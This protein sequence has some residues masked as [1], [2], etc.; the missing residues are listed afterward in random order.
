M[1]SQNQIS[2]KILTLALLL[3]AN[4]EFWAVNF[5]QIQSNPL[6]IQT[7]AF[8]E[9]DNHNIIDFNYF[10]KPI[11][12]ILN[13]NFIEIYCY[14][15]AL[16][17][18]ESFLPKLDMKIFNKLNESNN[19]K[20]TISKKL[21]F[22]NDNLIANNIISYGL[23]GLGSYAYPPCGLGSQAF[24]P[25]YTNGKGG[26]SWTSPSTW[27]D[28]KV[29]QKPEYIFVAEGDILTIDSNISI[30]TLYLS[31]KSKV[32]PDNNTRIIEITGNIY[33]NDSASIISNFGSGKLDCYITAANDGKSL[34]SIAQTAKVNFE[35]LK[36]LGETFFEK[37]NMDVMNFSAIKQKD[38][39]IQT[40]TVLNIRQTK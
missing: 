20:D 35:N 12:P 21:N 26:G 6:L 36:I 37:G 25:V 13:N 1:K 8:G 10:Y 5:G 27:R 23:C 9:R 39:I 18:N 28:G 3:L 31:K 29:P 40:G 14:S 38:F 22:Y 32:L 7:Q 17:P 24:D 33:V 30:E 11:A 19:S 4:C 34:I 2:L 16:Y 15:D